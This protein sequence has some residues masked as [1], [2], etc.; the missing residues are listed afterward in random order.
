MILDLLVDGMTTEETLRGHLA[1][2]AVDTLTC[3]A[4][5]ADMSRDYNVELR[6][7]KTA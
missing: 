2:E 4:Y 5:G 3:I 7:G 1:L 6:V